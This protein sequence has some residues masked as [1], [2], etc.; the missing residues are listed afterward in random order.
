MAERPIRQWATGYLHDRNGY[1]FDPNQGTVVVEPTGE[2][3][4]FWVGAP[5][6]TQDPQDGAIYLVYRVRRPR[7]VEPD[8]G[9]EIHI[10]RSQDGKSF[11]TVWTGHKATLNT[12]SI[13]RCALVPQNDGKWVLFPSYVDPADGRWRTDRV[14]A[15]DP[16]A[17]D[18]SQVEC[19]LTAA[20]TRTEGVKDPFVFHVAGLW[21][22]IVSCATQEGGAA[23]DAMHGTNDAYNTGLIKSR[24]GL[25]TSEDGREWEWEGEILSPSADGWDCYCAR[26]GTIWRED[27]VWLGL[28][29][30]SASVEENYEE[31]VGLAFSFDLRNWHRV[32]RSGPLMQQPHAS[33]ALRYFDVL[34]LGNRKLVYYET[35]RADGSHDLRVHEVTV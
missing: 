4:G 16:S 27:G 7:G 22:M 17:F 32:T 25:A 12:T 14:S 13:E 23:A 29:D 24:T 5:S 11:E 31:R 35:A 19:V 20:D 26:I 6:V 10:A 3:K 21:H 15:T 1:R 18:L 8:R 34:D 33:G 30:G 28:Y 2:G 9:A